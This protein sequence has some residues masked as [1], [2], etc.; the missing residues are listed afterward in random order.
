MGMNANNGRPMASVEVAEQDLVTERVPW[1]L[2]FRPDADI[3]VGATWV[4]TYTI[5]WRDFV[6]E[7]IGFTGP[8]EGFPA[9]PSH[10][11]IGLEDV[12]KSRSWQPHLFNTTALIGGN[13]GSS[14]VSAFKMSTP[15]T[16]N[17]KGTLR[18]Q[19]QND[20]A[21]AGSPTMVLHGYLNVGRAFR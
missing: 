14:D 2:Q 1:T 9:G 20:G 7:Y 5:P 19:I 12:G 15:W 17:E 6:I 18:V 11:N 21:F 16:V 4:D 8:Q 13:H 10:W 3:A